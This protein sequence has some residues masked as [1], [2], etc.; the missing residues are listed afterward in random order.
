MKTETHVIISRYEIGKL[1][2]QIFAEAY[3]S[4]ANRP[5]LM[6]EG[7]LYGFLVSAFEY[8]DD[9]YPVLEVSAYID[10]QLND[11]NG[12]TNARQVW[13]ELYSALRQRECHR[14]FDVVIGKPNDDDT[15]LLT[16]N[17][18]LMLHKLKK[19]AGKAIDSMEFEEVA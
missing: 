8:T 16:L 6:I 15:Q 7:G 19:A 4:K 5:T 2:D 11:G 9:D 3:A 18:R 17:V 14:W 12:F 1:C 13:R 10:Y